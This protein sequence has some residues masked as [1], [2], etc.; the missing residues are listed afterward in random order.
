MWLLYSVAGSV[1]FGYG[2]FLVKMGMHRGGSEQ[3]I[4]LGLYLAGT[5]GFVALILK[6][7]S[8]Q[9]SPL[10]ALA[11]LFIGAGSVFGNT[12]FVK[13]LQHGPL[14][15]TAPLTDLNIVCIVVLSVILYDESLEARKWLAIGIIIIATAAIHFYRGEHDTVTSRRWYGFVGISIIMLM[16]R[17]G[18]LKAAEAA[19]LDTTSI[20]LLAY[21]LGIVWFAIRIRRE[22]AP[23]SRAER[24]IGIRYGLMVGVASSAGLVLYSKGLAGGPA[25][26]V[27]PVF[28]TYTS[29][30][31]LFSLL[32][33]K[34]RLTGMQLAAVAGIIG[35]VV[36]LHV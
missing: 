14:G 7:G 22:K 34:E 27:V 28:S 24:N 20:L 12:Y 29:I 11:A 16:F 13:A 8:F 5:V 9:L 15:L 30:T 23:V 21:I 4:L 6:A 36:L 3:H 1:I 2:V 33:L 31:V 19:A 26:I 35:G 17:N 18:G 25:V 10:I 32:F